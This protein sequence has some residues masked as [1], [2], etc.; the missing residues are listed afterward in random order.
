MIKIENISENNYIDLWIGCVGNIDKKINQLIKCNNSGT[1]FV[2]KKT[3]GI[4]TDFDEFEQ[5]IISGILYSV[6]KQ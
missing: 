1:Q 3:E 6:N 4:Q 2:F 5:G